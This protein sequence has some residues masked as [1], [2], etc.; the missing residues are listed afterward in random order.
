MHGKRQD[1]F[2]TLSE[3]VIVPGDAIF[4]NNRA[5]FLSFRIKWE[6]EAERQEKRY[7][8]AFILVIDNSYHV[9]PAGT[10]PRP[11]KS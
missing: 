9:F 5:V 4:V 11:I 6:G 3:T 1:L 10:V 2:G 8:P 7:F